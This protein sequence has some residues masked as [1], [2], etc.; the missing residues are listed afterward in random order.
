M[1]PATSVTLND[2]IHSALDEPSR[3]LRG[4]RAPSLLMPSV[5]VLL[6]MLQPTTSLS[7][8]RISLGRRALGQCVLGAGAALLP[9]QASAS[10]AMGGA[11]QNAQSWEP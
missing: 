3:A 6:L 5:A 9:Q 11:A 1:Y 2:F 7:L 4:M 10:Y 8:G